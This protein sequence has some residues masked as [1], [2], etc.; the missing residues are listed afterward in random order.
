MGLKLVD[1][2]NPNEID[3][4][5]CLGENQKKCS[6]KSNSTITLKD[7]E[8]IYGSELVDKFI[9]IENVVLHLN[10]PLEFYTLY[11]VQSAFI[12]HK[13]KLYN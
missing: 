7:F 9:N 6:D 12:P 13:H 11:K 5:K 3:F 10:H 1:P 2:W 4:S 8:D